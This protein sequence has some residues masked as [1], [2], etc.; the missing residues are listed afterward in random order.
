VSTIRDAY[1]VGQAR[2]SKGNL[3]VRYTPGPSGM[4]GRVPRLLEA[5]HFRYTGRENGY[6]GSPSKVKKFEKMVADGWNATYFGKLES[7]EEQ[8]R[9]QASTEERLAHIRG[10]R[11][12]APS[13]PPGTTEG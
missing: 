7:P 12:A 2:Y 10:E 6:V 4:K 1:T 9:E 13:L 5:L 8:A 3:I 11:V